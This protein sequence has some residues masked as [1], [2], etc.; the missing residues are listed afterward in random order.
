ML[1]Q[2]DIYDIMSILDFTILLL[3]GLGF[4]GLIIFGFSRIRN[5]STINKSVVFTIVGGINIIY[6]VINQRL[7]FLIYRLLGGPIFIWLLMV[8]D[9]LTRLIPNIILL[10]TFGVLFLFLGDENRQNFGKYLMYSGIF[11]MVFGVISVIANLYIILDY[12]PGMIPYPLNLIPYIMI[13][14]ASS[15][16]VTSSILFLLYAYKID[17]KIILSSAISL[18]VAS[19]IFTINSI[20]PLPDIIPLF[21]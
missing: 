15:F 16:M 11:W 1:F 7:Y 12:D 10:I 20:L 8:Q 13:P 9:V 4:L 19:I 21:P 2:Y 18:L 14:I 17:N 6:L 5:R 3:Q